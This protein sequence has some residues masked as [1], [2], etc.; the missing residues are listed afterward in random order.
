MF[1]MIRSV[2]CVSLFLKYIFLSYVSNFVS[3]IFTLKMSLLIH[4]ISF[5]LKIH[6]VII[7]ILDL[8]YI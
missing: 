2:C 8:I 5:A 1:T 6:V 4:A 3:I 7:F